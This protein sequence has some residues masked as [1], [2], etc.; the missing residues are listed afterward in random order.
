MML[1][2]D[3]F[4]DTMLKSDMEDGDGGI[5]VM[6]YHLSEDNLASPQSPYVFEQVSY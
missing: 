3:E 6:S 4:L 2:D 1:S 5:G